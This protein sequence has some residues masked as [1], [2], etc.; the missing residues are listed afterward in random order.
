MVVDL[1]PK[2]TSPLIRMPIASARL[3]AMSDILFFMFP[4]PFLF[5]SA[6]YLSFMSAF[7]GCLAACGGVKPSLQNRD[8]LLS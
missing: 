4:S 2:A 5:I 1:C 6:I 3:R 7:A 8:F